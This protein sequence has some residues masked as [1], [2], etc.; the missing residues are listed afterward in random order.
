MSLF[1]KSQKKIKFLVPIIGEERLFAFSFEYKDKKVY[2]SKIS[3]YLDINNFLS[4]NE[5]VSKLDKAISEVGLDSSQE[6]QSAFVLEQSFLIDKTT[7][8]SDIKKV[9]GF[10]VKDLGL[11]YLGFFSILE[12]ILKSVLDSP[13]FKNSLVFFIEKQKIYAYLVSGGKLLTKKPL[14]I[15]R[16]GNF[17]FDINNLVKRLPLF[18]KL[19]YVVI[20]SLYDTSFIDLKYIKTAIGLKDLKFYILDKA[21]FSSL[22]LKVGAK[23]ILKA[24]EID[25][26][27][28]EISLPVNINTFFSQNSFS[29]IE[30]KIVQNQD[31]K[32]GVNDDNYGV[33]KKVI[34]DSVQIQTYDG[35]NIDLNL[36]VENEIKLKNNKTKN[37]KKPI[38]YGLGFGIFGVFIFLNFWLNKI[39][40]VLITIQPKE[41]VIS[42]DISIII[43]SDLETSSSSADLV[44]FKADKKYL[45]LED[46]IQV[47]ATGK[48]KKGTKSKGKMIFYNKSV[49]ASV[50]LK[51]GTVILDDSNNKKF[52]LTQDLV[53]PKG[54]KNEVEGK[55]EIIFGKVEGEV[56]GYDIGV[57]YNATASDKKYFIK[58]LSDD[59]YAIVSEDIQGGSEE[60]ITVVSEDDKEEA[61]SRLRKDLLSEAKQKLNTSQKDLYKIPTG[62]VI[63]EDVSLNPP[64]GD[65]ASNVVVK[66][67]AKVEYFEY[68]YNDL[69]NIAMNLLSDEIP[70]NYHLSDNEISV[71]VSNPDDSIDSQTDSESENIKVDA[72]INMVVIADIDKEKILNRALGQNVDSFKKEMKSRSEI[73]DLDITAYPDWF[74]TIKRKLPKKPENIKVIVVL[75]KL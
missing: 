43:D 21:E 19:D 61:L 75:K 58:G 53:I 24:T 70:A 51:K 49:D 46:S 62:K 52:V 7:L 54:E 2:L 14:F 4:Q 34:D 68:S 28:L 13:K 65:E 71:L 11:K 17:N 59:V 20:Y 18:T 48:D 10:L 56:E 35:K 31:S 36:D 39:Y 60:E 55:E 29:N 66:V 33:V 22:V 57:E 47:P 16:T 12:I 69:K 23:S 9:L 1:S 30:D 42:K 73:E 63:F 45:E 38:L 64:I 67:K 72:N 50:S 37:L 27:D 26:A 25:I 32:F 8:N 44:Y 15:Q 5:V 40:K 3:S 6:I 41:K 74:L